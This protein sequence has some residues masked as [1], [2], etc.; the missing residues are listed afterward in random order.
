MCELL[1]VL[2]GALEHEFDY[3]RWRVCGKDEGYLG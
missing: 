2:R 1:Y 3:N